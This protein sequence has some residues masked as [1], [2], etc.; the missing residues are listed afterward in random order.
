MSRILLLAG[1]AVVAVAAA[2][3]G[4][5]DPAEPRSREPRLARAASPGVAGVKSAEE[6]AGAAAWRS[7]EA[8][9]PADLAQAYEPPDV[10]A[11][12]RPLPGAADPPRRAAT[13]ATVPAPASNET[14]TPTNISYVGRLVEGTRVM[15]MI[16]KGNEPLLLKPGDSPEAGFV[17]R[18]ITEEALVL[19]RET[20][21]LELTI[22]RGA[23]K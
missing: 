9:R 20:D 12:R 5:G 22:P 14:Q 2:S 13:V 18:Q 3:I 15:A 23:G 7:L 21:G 1:A 19:A 11:P 4:G 16:M 10:F 8:S 6:T 17:I